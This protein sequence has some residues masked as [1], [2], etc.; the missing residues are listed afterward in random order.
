M[1]ELVQLENRI[2]EFEKR[3]VR[4]MAVTIEDTEDA[5]KT[6]TKVPHIKIISDPQRSLLNAVQ[7]IHSKANPNGNDAARPMTIL[8]DGNGTVKWVYKPDSFMVRPSPDDVL[9]AIDSNLTK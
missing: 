9:V 3:K 7:A 2:Q 4:V 1:I 6:Q 5:Q 8:L